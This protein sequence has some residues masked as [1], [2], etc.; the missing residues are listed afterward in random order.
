MRHVC[1][2]EVLDYSFLR[3]PLGETP[4]NDKNKGEETK[5]DWSEPRGLTFPVPFRRNGRRTCP[6][7]QT[8]DRGTDDTESRWQPRHSQ[9][10]ELRRGTGDTGSFGG[11]DKGRDPKGGLEDVNFDNPTGPQ[12]SS[13]APR[14]RRGRHTCTDRVSCR[15]FPESTFS[16]PESLLSFLESNKGQRM[17]STFVSVR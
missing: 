1:N 13:S 12:D 3:I 8:A 9:L 10:K 17:Q 15:T 6:P 4:G 2:G 14:W 7:Q 5:G 16:D 11:K